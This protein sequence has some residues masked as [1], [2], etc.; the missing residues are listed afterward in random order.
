MLGFSLIHPELPPFCTMTVPSVNSNI[1]PGELGA[2]LASLI[3]LWAT[4]RIG[5]VTRTIDRTKQSNSN[6]RLRLF[7][8]DMSPPNQALQSTFPEGSNTERG[9]RFF[10]LPLIQL[11]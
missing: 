8:F 4:L 9:S 10:V 6:L 2:K 3:Q 11:S 5:K 1:V 7:L